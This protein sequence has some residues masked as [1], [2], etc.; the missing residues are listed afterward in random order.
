[1]YKWAQWCFCSMK[2]VESNDIER[3]EGKGNRRETSCT[4]AGSQKRMPKTDK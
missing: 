1:M 3:I 2:N 4:V